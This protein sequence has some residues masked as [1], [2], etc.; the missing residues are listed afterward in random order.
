MVVGMVLCGVVSGLV[1][2]IIAFLVG[3][4][5]VSVLFVYC[6][7]GLVGSLSFVL[8]ALRRSPA[9]RVAFSTHD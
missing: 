1:A 4:G 7:A 3:H 5:I 8:M 2:A 9:G 6:L